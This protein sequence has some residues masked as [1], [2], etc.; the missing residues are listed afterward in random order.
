MATK[1]GKVREKQQY[2]SD[3]HDIYLA[4]RFF[5]ARNEGCDRAT[6]CDY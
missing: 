5:P 4:A 3:R 2:L 1:S 6:R